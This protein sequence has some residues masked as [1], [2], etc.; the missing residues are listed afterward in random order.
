MLDDKEDTVFNDLLFVVHRN[1]EPDSCGMAP[2]SIASMDKA[3]RE[4][5]VCDDVLSKYDTEA[6]LT[7]LLINQLQSGECASTDNVTAVPESLAGFCDM[8]SL[9]TVIQPDHDLLVRVP[10][11]SL[12]CRFHTRDGQRIDSLKTLADVARQAKDEAQSSCSSSASQEGQTCSAAGPTL[13]LYAVPAGRMF[14][15]APSFVGEKFV[16]DRMRDSAPGG[17]PIVVEV[18]SLQPRVFE[19]HNFYSLEEADTILQQALNETTESHKFHRSTTGAVDGRVF[20][21]RTS[22]NAWLTHTNEAGKVK[23]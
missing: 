3:L 21:R 5:N 10:G 17:E 20:S 8:G 23:R 11:G 19:L 12:P 4:M 2:S 15:F 13:H 7:T 1:G 22:E 9:R 14:M 18:L 16:L 6:F